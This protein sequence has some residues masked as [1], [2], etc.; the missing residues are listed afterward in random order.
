MRNI[1]ETVWP[2]QVFSSYCEISHV[3]AANLCPA[4]PTHPT[5][6]S[7]TSADWLNKLGFIYTN[8]WRFEFEALENRFV[9]ML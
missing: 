8:H 4:T 7:E 9:L 2:V 6:Q 5:S 3:N 1:R